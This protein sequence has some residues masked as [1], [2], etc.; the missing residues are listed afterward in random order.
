LINGEPIDRMSTGF[1]LGNSAAMDTGLQ[2]RF[3]DNYF[4]LH[5][6]PT[7]LFG[8]D[9]YSRTY[10]SAN[11]NPL[12]WSEELKAA[13][14]MG[15]NLYE[16]LQYNNPGHR[17]T[18]DDWRSFLAM[19]QLTQRIG[20][21]FM[22]GMLIGH[23]VAVGDAELA[24]QSALCRQYAER[25][26]NTPGL[27]YY[28]NGDY[29]MLPDRSPDAIRKLWNEW[30]ERRYGTIER[31]RVAWGDDAVTGGLGELDFPPPNSGRWD[32]VAAVDRLRF[33]TWLTRRWNE[34]HVA[35]VRSVDADH[36]VT[37][38][39][40]SFPFAG[41]DLPMTIDGQDVSNI[42]YF[43]EPVADL[44]NL[45][46]KIRFNDLRARGKGVSLGE[47]GVKTH[48]A[49]T[50]EN[51][52]RG[53]HL[54]RTEQE[55]KQLF[56]AVA[57]YALGLGASKVQNWCLRDAQARVFPWGVFYPN[58]LVPKDV[59]YTHRNLSIVW[60]YFRPR[61]AA[62]T[63]T[64]CLANQL[65]LGNDEGLGP[66]VAF[67]TFADLLAL[68]YDFNC[69]DDHHLQSLPAATAVVVYPTPFALR[70]ETYDRLRTWVAGGGTLLVTGDFSYDADRQRTRTGRLEELAGCR[71]VA[72]NY[73]NVVR[74]SAIDVRS[75]S[76]LE[77][78][79]GLAVRPCV[80]VHATSAKVLA[81]AEDETPVLLRRKLGRGT[82]YFFT[83]PIELADGNEA[84]TARRKLYAAILDAANQKS[85]PVEPNEPW[86]HVMAQ[87]TVGGTVHVVFNT[88]LD[89]GSVPVR[90]P[91]A[92]G[93][94][95][96]TTRNRWPALAAATADGKLIAVVADGA[97]TIDGASVLA[98]RGLKALLALDGNDLRD[99]TAV[100]VAPFEPG[101][102]A[103]PKKVGDFVASVGEFRGGKWS[104]LERLTLEEDKR[105]L[106]IDADHATCLILVSE[107]HAV[108]H[109]T[110][111][112]TNAMCRPDKIQG[113]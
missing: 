51:G 4:S 98:G 77:Q 79:D 50:E 85:L 89:A 3:A 31:L 109:W 73:S 21:V 41:L 39:Y 102:V 26:G 2:L 62:P 44:D 11:E 46:L 99:S 112:L 57:H 29:Q 61:Y 113:Y 25:L 58:Q 40:Y 15:M 16:N 56:L 97:A 7:F 82:V 49:W 81:T 105:V 47:Y 22:P 94:V 84:A 55:Q 80:R 28:I 34:A 30:I 107:S 69:I 54:V 74:S 67:R 38:E 110:K 42:G 104:E 12:T 100:L 60:R 17:M 33:Q 66:A 6:R 48:P 27:L 108:E 76:S 92:A 19:T 18:E 10:K 35:A 65:R 52:A 64:V 8:T 9:I 24:E 37:S 111:Q 90:L 83:D 14:D 70:D 87:P 1:V 20:L 43:D 96:L 86:L 78:L 106:E 59:A 53:Y 5:G 93:S 71:F 88:K 36:P 32:D 95:E 103:L 68:H 72:E 45:P 63:L 91:T 75:L 23:N 101:S 13:R